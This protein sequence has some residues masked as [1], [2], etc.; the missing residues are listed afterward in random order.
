MTNSNMSL[1]VF[2]H[3][4]LKTAEHWNLSETGKDIAI[5]KTINYNQPT[6]I[7]QI[8]ESDYLFGI[9]HICKK[10][11][12]VLPNEYTSF[13]IVAHSIGCL[14]AIKMVQ[15]YDPQKQI[16]GLILI[17]PTTKTPDY[18]QSLKTKSETGDKFA[19]AKLGDYENLPDPVLP[20]RLITNIHINVQLSDNQE[21]LL[22]R[23]ILDYLHKLTCKNS[24]SEKRLHT[25][26]S[27]MIHYKDPLA[28][29]DSITQMLK[30][31]DL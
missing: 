19:L 5:E 28:I 21:F 4:F 15:D 7:I 27:H 23:E 31:I 1:V 24:K 6:L 3:G 30:K 2:I 22:K 29:I 8:N 25:N 11:V 16:R 17:E 14:Y 13:L 10:I 9:H 12:S 26:K 18:Y 20:T